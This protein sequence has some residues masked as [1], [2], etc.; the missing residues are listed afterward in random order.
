MTTVEGNARARPPGSQSRHGDR[1]ET[2]RLEGRPLSD[3]F[4]VRKEAVL[5][6]LTLT[7][8]VIRVLTSA[9]VVAAI[10]VV[11]LFFSFAQGLFFALL[12]DVRARAQAFRTLVLDTSARFFAARM[13]AFWAARAVEPR[14][15]VV[16]E[17]SRLATA[18]EGVG[19]KQVQSIVDAE[20]RIGMH[21]NALRSIQQPDGVDSASDR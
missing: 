12:A 16:S 11:S 10:L 8:T 5:E 7:P 6:P 17:L 20:R 9:L 15:P 21:L 3:P 4:A 18:V 13:T 19:E 1:R 2:K 14:A